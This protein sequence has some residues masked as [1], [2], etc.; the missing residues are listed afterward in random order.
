M[1]IRFL[2]VG[3]SGFVIDSATTYLLIALGLPAW[4]ARV[5]AICLAMLFT[6]LANRTFTYQSK[7]QRS[8]AELASY[9]TVAIT[10]AGLNYALY[11]GLLTLHTEPLL[12][13]AIAT[14][15]QSCVSFFAYKHLVFGKGRH[16]ST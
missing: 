2:L 10:M 13:I 8:A 5:P 4:S 16:E 3:G 14:A 12:A 1:F 7:Q 6:W 11:L 15:T 9:V